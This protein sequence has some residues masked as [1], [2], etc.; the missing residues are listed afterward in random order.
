MDRT[1]SCSIGDLVFCRSTGGRRGTRSDGRCAGGNQS[2]S[3]DASDNANTRDDV[4]YFDE[5]QRHVGDRQAIHSI[6][7]RGL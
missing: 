7:P 4:Q 1:T 2:L 3:G 6:D 5:E